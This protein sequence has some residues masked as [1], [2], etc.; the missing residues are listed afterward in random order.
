[1]RV[2]DGV[3][4]GDH[5]YHKKLKILQQ[6]LTFGA[7][8]HT[9]FTFTGVHLQQRAASAI[10]ASQADY[11]K[12]ISPVEIPRNRRIAPESGLS[13]REISQLRGILG[14]IQYAV[15]HSRPDLA[16]R[17]SE[18]QAQVTK[19]TVR[20]LPES[21]KQLR[22]AQENA[23]VSITYL[24][25][26]PLD[27]TF[28]SFGDASFASKSNLSSHQGTII[29]ATTNRLNDNIQAPL[30]PLVWISKKIARVVRSTLSAEA[31]AM[32][33]SVDLLGWMRMM[34]G[35]IHIPEFCWERPAEAFNM[36]HPAIITTDCKSL[37]DLV[38]RTAIPSCE[39][40]RTTLEVLLIRQRCKEH[41]VFR[42]VPTSLMLADGLTKAM[43]VDLLREILRLGTFKLYERHYELERNAHRKAALDWLRN[44][45]LD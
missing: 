21:N 28:V 42:W 29:A 23:S 15:T 17:L 10:V 31:Y 22:D 5:V 44:P 26:D 2:D 19:P 12:R 33:K 4:G 6:K 3:G 24:P 11:G 20:S 32:S 43:S 9:S 38:T 35:C 27:L 39:E 40:Y 45:K 30:S 36:L 7:E 41:C 1:M 13:E 16:A 8:K 37:Y 34:W 18:I 14:S 25:I